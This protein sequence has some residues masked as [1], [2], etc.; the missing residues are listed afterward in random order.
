MSDGTDEPTL[1]EIYWR[2][3]MTEIGITVPYADLD[4][5]TR[6]AVEAGAAAAGAAAIA[7]LNQPAE[8][9]AAMAENVRL[10]ELVAEILADFWPGERFEGI[11]EGLRDAQA[12]VDDYRERAGL[13]RQ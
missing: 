3:A 9:R 11:S 7:R 10:R 2:G 5:Q 13:E 6:R 12:R 1:G 4:P 8:L